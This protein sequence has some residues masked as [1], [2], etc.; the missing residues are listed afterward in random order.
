MDAEA[1]I[2]QKN[3]R[4]FP[5]RLFPGCRKNSTIAQRHKME[6]RSPGSVSCAHNARRAEGSWPM[7]ARSSRRRREPENE[8]KCRQ[9]AQL[10]SSAHASPVQTRASRPEEA[11]SGDPEASLAAGLLRGVAVRGQ[12]VSSRNDPGRGETRSLR[13][14]LQSFTEQP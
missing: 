10:P 11:A 13:P 8:E 7:R 5:V 1:G 3:L 2:H 14:S 12:H 4:V 6:R 9:A